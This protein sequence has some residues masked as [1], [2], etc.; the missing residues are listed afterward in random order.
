MGFTFTLDLEDHRSSPS[1][2]PRHAPVVHDLLE[3]LEAI[4]VQGTFFVVGT[5]AESEPELI[6]TIAA[7]GH[8]LALHDW[9]HTQLDRS[10]PDT[11]RATATK[12]REV[13]GDLAGTEIRGYRAA[14]FSLTADTVWAT[15]VLAEVGF[16][17]S[18]SVLAA[19]N[20]LY[21]FPEA[22]RHAF[23]WPSGLLELPAPLAD[24]GVTEVPLGG[25]YLRIL[26]A[27]LLRRRLGTTDVPFV[28]CH[29]YDF[30][31]DEPF[32]WEPVAGKLAPLL[33]V[34]RGRLWSKMQ[35]LL[36]DAGPPLGERV[37]ALDELPTFHPSAADSTGSGARRAIAEPERERGGGSQLDMVHRLPVAPC[38]DRRSYL[39]DLAI[40]RSVTHV[41]FVD[42]GYRAMQDRT[43][44][45]LHGH[46]AATARTLVGLDLDEVGVADARAAGFEAH[47]V[48]CRDA[49]AVAAA[50]V[51]PAEIVI[52]GEIIEH[53]DAPG[54][55][56]DGLHHLVADDGR[57]VVTTPNAA[58]LFNTVAALAHREVNHPDHVV[59]FTWRTLTRLLADHDFEVVESATFVPAVKEGGVL[60]AGA[61]AITGVERLAGRLGRPFLA[62][63][64][65]VVCRSLRRDH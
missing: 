25:T 33:W 55:F 29:P 59:S 2:A 5:L 60:G 34:G 12:G 61:R 47:A 49:D 21:G 43:G 11:L 58:G 7:Q 48:D 63:G 20:P 50:G 62:D 6:R 24:L 26:P 36:A 31:P 8:E 16:T 19:A 4:G 3:R 38:V 51:E 32:W 53:L 41:G 18:S 10:D 64:L 13:L 9:D 22:P 35:V 30:D 56:L 14:T 45:W 57:L 39:C 27:A 52:A 46:L 37:A 28:Y 54:P 23:G 40:G 42:Q 65:I 1:Q 17:Y 15:D 44:T